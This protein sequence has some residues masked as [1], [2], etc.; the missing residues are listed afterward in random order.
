VCTYSEQTISLYLLWFIVVEIA[1]RRQRHRVRLVLMTFFFFP[2][3]SQTLNRPYLPHTTSVEWM[4]KRFVY[5]VSITLS[6]DEIGPVFE[7]FVGQKVYTAYCA[8]P[9]GKHCSYLRAAIFIRLQIKLKGP[10]CSVK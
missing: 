6:R 3:R 8:A 10:A 1:R 5:N 7:R 9:Y 2:S 4:P